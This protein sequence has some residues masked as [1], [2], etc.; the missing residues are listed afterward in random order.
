MNVSKELITAIRGVTTGSTAILLRDLGSVSGKR[1]ADELYRIKLGLVDQESWKPELLG[2]R[3][4]EPS[5]GEWHLS[6]IHDTLESS[7]ER[8]V[9]QKQKLLQDNSKINT[10]AGN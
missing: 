6:R 8:S 10:I 5:R 3:Y 4:G 9:L 2:S 7:C 1:A